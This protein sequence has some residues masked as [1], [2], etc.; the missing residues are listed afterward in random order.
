[1]KR[2]YPIAP[3]AMITSMTCDHFIKAITNEEVKRWMCYKEPATLEE[4]VRMAIKV[5]S[6]EDKGRGKKSV[7]LVHAAR[8]TPVNEPSNEQKEM[9]MA[10]KGIQKNMSGLAGQVRELQLTI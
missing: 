6:R 9:I 5:E 7:R 10:L 4:A 3:P 2:T 1:M 8:S